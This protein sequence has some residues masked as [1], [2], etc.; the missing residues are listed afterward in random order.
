MKITRIETAVVDAGWR[1]WLFVRVETDTGVTGYGECSDGKNP[2][3]V[4][5]AIDDLKPLLLGADPRA[6]ETRFHDMIRGSRQSPGGIAAK[7]IAGIELAL[8]DAKARALG[9]P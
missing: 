7:A 9:I 4:A 8:V 3:G 1:P 2:F 5:G 6:Y